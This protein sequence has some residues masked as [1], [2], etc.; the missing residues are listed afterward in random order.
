MHWR[1]ISQISDVAST[2]LIEW[3]GDISGHDEAH[4]SRCCWSLHER[5]FGNLGSGAVSP[6]G[7]GLSPLRT[8]ARRKGSGGL[9]A[10]T[11]RP[12]ISRCSN[13]APRKSANAN[14][15]DIIT[16]SITLIDH[17]GKGSWACSRHRVYRHR[18]KNSHGPFR[19]SKPVSGAHA[20]PSRGDSPSPGG[21]YPR[22]PPG[23]RAAQSGRYNQLRFF[24][25]N[26]DGLPPRT[27]CSRMLTFEPCTLANQILTIRERRHADKTTTGPAAKD[28]GPID[29]DDA[30][31]S[32][33]TVE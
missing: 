6:S 11:S 10:P 16:G 5:C 27:L 33:A 26:L 25:A 14:G 30:E 2:S 24:A 15:Q 29:H 9:G 23:G 28:D 3:P 31:G 8:R 7:S 22:G 4:S 19:S 1:L 21:P 32:G 17:H 13:N 12:T 18:R 20:S